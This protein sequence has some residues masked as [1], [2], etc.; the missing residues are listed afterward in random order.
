MKTI[1]KIAVV[2]FSMQA[3]LASAAPNAAFQSAAARPVAV[4]I[5]VGELSDA[6]EMISAATAAGDD[7]KAGRLLSD[8]FSNGLKIEKAVPVRADEDAAP[9]PAPAS[10]GVVAPAL[11]DRGYRAPVT[12]TVKSAL[13]L[14]PS[15]ASYYTTA[16]PLPM[17][18][19]QK[20]AAKEAAEKA[21]KPKRVA[22]GFSILAIALLLLI[23][24]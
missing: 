12:G 3:G 24:L 13:G 23:L 20:D 2:T 9:V 6:S 11:A 4:N 15:I 5:T 1:V 14:K 17:T 10:A 19:E 22:W 18:A 7:L 16:Q 8:L 21:A